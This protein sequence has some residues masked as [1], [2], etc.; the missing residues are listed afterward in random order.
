MNDGEKELMKLWNLHLMKNRLV[1][2]H[3]IQLL[4]QFCYVVKIIILLTTSHQ[5]SEINQ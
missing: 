2:F 4:S 3:H 1:Y 5:K